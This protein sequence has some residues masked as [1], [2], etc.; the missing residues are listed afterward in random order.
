MAEDAKGTARDI[1]RLEAKVENLEE[2]VS[3]LRRDVRGIRETLAQARGGWKTLMLVAGAA[4]VAG[5]AFAKVL[6]F[7]GI[8]R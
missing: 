7:F 8:V 5:A 6:G 3:G 2:E 4:G 1:G